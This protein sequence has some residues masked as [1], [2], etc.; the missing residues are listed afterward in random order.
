[1][2]TRNRLCPL[3]ATLSLTMLFFG[4]VSWGDDYTDPTTLPGLSTLDGPSTP[5]STKN[6]NF[7]RSGCDDWVISQCHS[8]NASC[9]VGGNPILFI[10]LSAMNKRSIGIAQSPPE[11]GQPQ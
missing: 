10:G 9:S 1:M 11:G 8:Y 7:L 4:G 6:C 2:L 5:A 3:L